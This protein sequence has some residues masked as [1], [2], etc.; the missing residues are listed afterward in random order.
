MRYDGEI[1]GAT[2]G[3]ELLQS[4]E[5]KMVHV[6]FEGSYESKG[7]RIQ[8]PVFKLDKEPGE[9]AYYNLKFRA[10]TTGQCYWWVDFL[11]AQGNPLPDVNSAV[12]PNSATDDYNQMLYVQAAAVSMRLAFQSKNGVNVRDILVRKATPAE[13][14]Q[15]GDDLYA[16]LPPLQFQP[17]ANSFTLL[18][19][20][21]EALKS[22]KP[23]RIVML[24]DSIQNDSFNSVFQALLK[25]D[26]P[27]S[28]LDFVISV[29]G[30]TGCW[31]YKEPEHFA[32]YVA[33]YKPDLLLIGGISNVRHNVD[34]VEHAMG[35]IAQVIDHARELGCEIALLSPPHSVDWRPFDKENPD[36][37]LPAMTWTEDTP[38]PQGSKRLL[39]TP[40]RDLA[41]KEKIAFW[42]ITVPTMD[43]LAQSGK[44]HDYFNRDYVHNNDRG[45]Q[46]IGRTLQRYFQTANSRE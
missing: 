25:R 12:Y 5:G 4:E 27:Q 38:D 11:D 22:G 23:W 7:G 43:Y 39:W 8:S 13:A 40:Y 41:A 31:Y 34:S 26:F 29:R 6:P 33:K 17:P 20:T 16:T 35:N 36:A 14:A 2:P 15:W 30:S 44:P 21:A 18:P 32:E 19:K 45:K 9:P 10:R 24:G 28:N 37:A 3:W 42:N 1:T 46:I